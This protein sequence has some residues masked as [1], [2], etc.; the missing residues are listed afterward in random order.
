M[1]AYDHTKIEKKWQK[2]WEKDGLYAVPDKAGGKENYYALVE[3]PYPS[4]NLHIGHWYAFAVPDIFARYKRMKGYNTLFPIGFDAF[5]L[6]AENAAIK[7]GLDP[8]K[9]TYENIS[10]MTAQIQSMGASFDWSRQVITSDPEYY[11]WTQWLFLKLY[12]KGL[13]YRGKAVVNWD[14]VDKTV[15]ANEQV[16]PDGTAERSGAVVE[17]RE[18]EQWFL[19]ITDYADR[20]L[21]DLDG[22][23]W[24]EEI[25]E[26][27]RAWIGKSEGCEITFRILR[28]S[29]KDAEQTRNDAEKIQRQSVFGLRDSA[30]LTKVK[31]FT[32]RPDTLFGATYLVLAPEHSEI[33]NLKSKIE[34]WDE[35]E[36]YIKQAKN[37]KEIERTAEGKEKTG[38]RLEGVVAVNPANNEE[39]PVFVADYVLGGYGTGAVMAVPAHDDRDLQFALKFNLKIKPV[40]AQVGSPEETKIPGLAEAKLK[41]ILESGFAHVGNG[42]L[43]NSNQFNGLTNEEAKE[44]ITAFVKGRKK[45]TY[46]LRD[47]LISR[48]RYWGCPIPVVYAPDGTSHPIPEEHLPWLLPDDVDFTPTGEPPLASSKELRER[49]ERIFGKGWRPEYDTMD[50]FI[51]SSWYFLRYTDPN[52][53]NAFA[54]RES[55]QSWMPVKRYSG[56][57]EHTTM[58]LLYSRFFHKALFDIG[59]VNEPE[60]YTERFNRGII[61]GTD[62]QK[63]S[64]RWGNVIDPDKQVETVGADSVRMYLGFIGPYHVVGHYPW[65]MGGIVGVRRFLERVWNLSEKVDGKKEDD[66]ATEAILHQTTKKVGEDIE[67]FKFNTAI[68]QMMIFINELTKRDSVS[69]ETYATFLRLLA[70]FAPHITEE[71]WHSVLENKNSIHEEPWPLFDSKKIEMEEFVIAVSVDG[72]VRGQLAVSRHDSEEKIKE[73]ACGLDRVAKWVQDDG[74]RKIVYIPGRLVNIVTGQTKAES[75]G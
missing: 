42:F 32:T 38:V 27:Q 19:K 24:P 68:S 63:M 40:I 45:T 13:A 61:L 18:L 26:Q 14:P 69:N 15:L 21:S 66:A 54:S 59:I 74:I 41:S 73:M 33:E 52:N 6:P 48:Q 64:K 47:W 29:Q 12:E 2:K 16:L 49:T 17:K 37:K 11:K 57:A 10:R 1:S 35:V 70:P 43:I 25:K 75:K 56:G 46:K 8:K 20:L 51:D 34:N 72:K 50:T 62:G 23:A 36:K 28:S 30:T 3:F 7:H 58:H 31:V 44:K 9:W 55:L 71:L 4:G 53:T 39:I 5:G 60:P 22:L 67:A 65:D